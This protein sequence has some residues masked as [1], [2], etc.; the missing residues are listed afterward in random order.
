MQRPS[1]VNAN[2]FKWPDI[3]DLTALSELPYQHA[4]LNLLEIE[5]RMLNRYLRNK[6]SPDQ[7]RERLTS[8]SPGLSRFLNDSGLASAM[9]RIRPTDTRLAEEHLYYQ[10]LAP[11]LDK[12]IFEAFQGLLGQDSL[13]ELAQ[14]LG[15]GSILALH[16]LNLLNVEREL[17]RAKAEYRLIRS[18]RDQFF[19]N[20]RWERMACLNWHVPDLLFFEP[21]YS[22]AE[23]P[24]IDNALF[25]PLLNERK[26]LAAE[27]GFD[28]FSGL[29]KRRLGMLG[30]SNESLS[31]LRDAIVKW[32]VPIAVRSRSLLSIEKE[33]D[34][35]NLFPT[36][37]ATLGMPDD[38]PLPIRDTDLLELE[39]SWGRP[40]PAD[41]PESRRNPLNKAVVQIIETIL[42]DQTPHYFQG[43]QSHGYIREC[44]P[45]HR[46]AFYLPEVEVPFIAMSSMRETANLPS[47]IAL[48]GYGLAMHA[49]HSEDMLM[50]RH[51]AADYQSA[52]GWGLLGLV[53][54]RL[55]SAFP[56]VEEGTVVCDAILL[57]L[58]HELIYTAMLEEFQEFC[59]GSDHDN[60]SMRNEIWLSLM[61]RWYP[62][63]ADH[64]E[65]LLIQE[66]SWRLIPA[67]VL[68]PYYSAAEFSARLVALQLWDLSRHAEKKAANTYLQFITGKSSDSLAES[69]ERSH[70]KSVDDIDVVKRLAYQ[71]ADSLAY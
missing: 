67:L 43:L 64:H 2:K 28:H 51:P 40:R 49:G 8:F 65:W 57:K 62:D 35:V 1:S 20:I 24:W 10:D 42:A 21:D 31:V 14:E 4:R 59:Y 19:P 25:E 17:P 36:A 46:S 44:L 39:Q 47:S 30:D 15:K 50:L 7:I 61:E 13:F 56:S 26:L 55:P 34:P 69:L 16:N 27:Q 52:R 58:L 71:L 5:G 38:L 60:S 32:L 33:Q 68:C 53:L 63:L 29:A 37:A 23:L 22:E 11:E 66:E 48:L 45:E 41:S 70:M 12:L 6:R 3:S 9:Y 18:F 54:N